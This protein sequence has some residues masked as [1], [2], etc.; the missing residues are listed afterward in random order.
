M[1]GAS[2]GPLPCLPYRL[3]RYV[4]VAVMP[5]RSSKVRTNE[6]ARQTENCAIFQERAI[7]GFSDG[8]IPTILRREVE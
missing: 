8:L 3:V 7:S 6:G 5:Q 4:G 2:H 1:A